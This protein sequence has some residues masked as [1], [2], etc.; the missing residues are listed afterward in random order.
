MVQKKTFLAFALCVIGVAFAQSFSSFH[1]NMYHFRESFLN[2][3]KPTIHSTKVFDEDH[4][5]EYEDFLTKEECE[6]LIK[7][8]RG[9]VLESKV[10]CKDGVHCFNKD[11]RTSRNAFVNDESHASVEKIT[12]KVEEIMGMHRKYFEDLQIVH[13]QKGQLYTEH[14]DACPEMNIKDC[15]THVLTSGQRYAT[16]LIYLNDDFEGGETCFPKR[17]RSDGTCNDLDT[18]KVK[19]KQGKAVLFFNLNPDG[20]SV[21]P[22]SLHAGLPPTRGEKWM[23]N[24][25]IRTGPF[26]K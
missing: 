26:V 14:F 2:L 22:E 25:W 21:K 13:Y 24:K 15:D 5:Y 3:P 10:V 8:A 1:E 16:F 17:I 20:V 7:F 19:P 18:Y 12:K 6:S 9:K 4:I 23:C 11:V